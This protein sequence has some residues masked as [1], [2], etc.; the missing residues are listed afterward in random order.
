MIKVVDV[1]QKM[2]VFAPPGVLAGSIEQEWSFWIPK[3]II[4]DALGEILLRIE[5]PMC[6]FSGKCG[7][8]KFR[9]G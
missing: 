8:V 3:F 7:S 5:G 9:V 2:D 4:R 1:L 6:T